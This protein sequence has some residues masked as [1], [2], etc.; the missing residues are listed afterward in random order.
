MKA[1]KSQVLSFGYVN[2]AILSLVI[3]M[4]RLELLMKLQKAQN[5]LTV[6]KTLAGVIKIRVMI[7]II[8]S[9][10]LAGILFSMTTI[11]LAI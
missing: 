11:K 5:V 8:G 4:V 6:L 7:N 9:A 2:L 10:L 1:K 3:T